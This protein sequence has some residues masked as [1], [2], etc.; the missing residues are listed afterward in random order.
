MEAI[1]IL[2]ADDNKEFR[3]SIRSVLEIEQDM[4]LV[5]E[6]ASFEET[7]TV[8]TALQPDV[9]LMDVD[10]GSGPKDKNNGIEATR[11]ISTMHSHIAILI[12]TSYS[13]D[14]IIIYEAMRFG[15]RGY[16]VKGSSRA[17]IIRHI[18]A[19]AKGEI[20]INVRVA[21]RV[22]NFFADMPSSVLPEAFPELTN[23]EREILTLW[24]QGVTKNDQLAE[25]LSLSVQTIKNH[26]SNIL[27]KLDVANRADAII[28]AMN[29]R[30]K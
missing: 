30:G 10:F 15:A 9:I 3:E 12:T 11:I 21:K 18:R 17:D 24:T 29:D 8:A 23:R 20:I 19:V 14:D 13:E 7:L 26:S 6:A 16:L 22:Q 28:K 1:R 4:E 5:G 27:N 2:V 25:H